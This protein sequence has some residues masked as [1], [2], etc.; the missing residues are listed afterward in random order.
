MITI[1]GFTIPLEMALE[2]SRITLNGIVANCSQDVLDGVLEEIV[3]K[4]GGSQVHKYPEYTIIK[5]HT[6]DGTRDVYI[7]STDMDI[8]IADQ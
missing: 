2:K 7:G 3:Y 6:L 8:H 4:D 5:Y 1:K